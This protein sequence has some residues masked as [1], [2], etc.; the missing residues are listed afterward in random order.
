MLTEVGVWSLWKAGQPVKLEKNGC[1]GGGEK[2]T[3]PGFAR[4][5]TS[6]ASFLL[7]FPIPGSLCLGKKRPARFLFVPLLCPSHNTSLLGLLGV[8][9]TPQAALGNEDSGNVYLRSPSATGAR[10]PG[11]W[12]GLSGSQASAVTCSPCVYGESRDSA[13]PPFP[14]NQPALECGQK[15]PAS[16]ALAPEKPWWSGV[17]YAGRVVRRNSHKDGASL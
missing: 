7:L 8:H 1:V 12:S 13:L 11:P 5:K 10:P 3:K 2:G 14:Y 16:A 15:E 4:R 6:H 17:S 9:V